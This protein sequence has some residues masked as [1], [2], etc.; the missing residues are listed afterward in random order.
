MT[1]RKFLVFPLPKF[2]TSI[3]IGIA[4][5]ALATLYIVAYQITPFLVGLALALG[6]ITIAASQF[7]FGW[8]SD[9][10]YLSKWGRRKPYLLILSPLLAISTIFLLMP[11]LI[12]SLETAN[13]FLWLLIWYQIFNF[14]YGVTTPYESWMAEQFTVDERPKASQ[15][16]NILG[17]LGTGVMAIFSIVVL[18]QFNDKV[19]LNPDVIPAEF[20]Y[21]VIAFCIILVVL[22]YVVVFFMDTEPHREIKTS[23]I[24]R[25]KIVLK[26]RNYL[27]V[28]VMVG[29][30]SL[31]WSM[32]GSLI[33]LFLEQ[34]LQ[35][36]LIF[37]IITAAT[38]LIGILVFLAIWRAMITNKGKKTTLLYVFLL[39]IIALPF[40][41]LGFIK[42]GFSV[43]YGI[44]FV[45]AIAGA[46]G[47]WYLFPAILMADLAEDDQRKT[48]ELKAGIYKGFPSIILN[49]FQAVGL[50]LLGVILEL[51]DISIGPTTYSLG[52][53]V[54][55]FGEF[56]FRFP[57]VFIDMSNVSIGYLLWGPIC[58]AILIGAYLFAR[59]FIIIDFDWE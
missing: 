14:S 51:P 59:K 56:S 55:R 40:S 25:L 34:V 21:S 16:L 1:E 58:S 19:K 53:N 32:I 10:T 11:S 5:F 46:M 9:Q 45:L 18:T 12:I 41:L 15:F 24:E 22:F 7:F 36:E 8:I 20:L 54:F 44:I 50:L 52:L 33:L 27:L 2:G 13:L 17:M 30:A 35:F 26:N 31:A 38:Y 6:K 23:M 57:T 43:I 48:G 37:Y 42:G 39:A 3:V 4:D 29:I 47:G 28:N 49:I